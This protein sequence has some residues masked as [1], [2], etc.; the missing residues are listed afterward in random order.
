LDKIYQKSLN[1]FLNLAEPPVV[2][3]DRLSLVLRSN[4][5]YSDPEI[6]GVVKVYPDPLKVRDLSDPK[7]YFE[8]R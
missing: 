5:R 1:F 4:I 7:Y 2:N 6:T 3:A 8:S